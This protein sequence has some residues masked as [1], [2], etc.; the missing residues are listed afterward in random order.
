M[1]SITKAALLLNAVRVP[2]KIFLRLCSDYDPVELWHSE[3]LWEELK[4]PKGMRE[5]LSEFL[6]SGWAEREDERTYQFGANFITS[7]NKDYPPRLLDLPKPPVGLY[8]KGRVNLLLPSVAIVGTRKCSDYAAAQATKLGR[9]L[10]QAGIMTISGGA[11]GIDSA[12]HRGTLSGNGVTVVVFGTGLDK[13]YPTENRD[14]F[15]MILERGAWVSEYPFGT[16]GNTWRFPERDRLIAGMALHVVVAES[17]ED[18]GAMHTL[19]RARELGRDTWAIPGRINEEANLGSNKAMNDGVKTLADI[20]EFIKAITEGQRQVS[21][22]FDGVEN[23]RSA[24]ELDD[25]EKIIY[26][27]L[28]RTG[29]RSDDDI[30]C[31]SGLEMVDVNIALMTLEAEGLIRNEGGRYSAV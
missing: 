4:I 26:S 6:A 17:P 13:T 5:R 28:Q 9:A 8:V 16:D 23:E 14:L 18:G 22:D 12:G 21:I 1:D 7:K 27:L 30:A 15:A 29:A 11:R 24:P 20:G 3:T 31:E 2:N 25:N 10:A 19:R